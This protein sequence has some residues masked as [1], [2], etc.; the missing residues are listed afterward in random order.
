M[1]G[2]RR[3]PVRGGRYQAW[4][5]DFAGNRH[6]FTGTHNR[7]E[8]LRIAE[9]LEDEHR[10]IRLGYRP[11]P[12][13]TNKHRNR[14]FSEVKD[15]Y[16]AWGT[17]QGGRGGRPW[18][19]THAR[20]RCQHLAWWQDRLDLDILGGLDNC[21]PRVEQALRDLQARGLAGKTLA[22]YAE[23]L[24]AICDWCVR[25]GY[26]ADDP[27]KNLGAFDITP[28]TRRRAMTTDEIIRL[29][30]VC[31]PHRRL[32]LE[33]AFL[34]G[35]RAGELRHLTVD[36]LDRKH[37]G[38]RLDAAWT[39]NRK[40]GFQP[41]PQALTERLH[42]FAKSGEPGRLYKRFYARRDALLKAPNNPLL[43]VP[44]HP[45]R[46]LACDLEAASIPK[47][48]PEGKLDF[49]ACRVAFI[50]F[51]IEEGATDKEAQALARHATPQLTFNVYARTR[52]ERL[53]STIEKVAAVLLPDEKCVP[54]VQQEG[55]STAKENATPYFSGV[56]S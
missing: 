55:S 22:N 51:V 35:L 49:H 27:L 32:L 28:R 26:L 44:S 11:P 40:S 43:Y 14:P 6:F 3:K 45:A 16:L 24:T 29:L 19:E 47:K 4:Y 41:L 10:Q 31:A 53:A 18:G 54:G 52:E 38:L 5:R 1:A 7:V 50:T 33:T 23:A 9:R 21:L 8:T 48:T 2:I 56:A 42:T 25:R 13:P 17:S 30:R 39:K 34:S 36:H 20:N 46:D 15:E 37:N 12:S